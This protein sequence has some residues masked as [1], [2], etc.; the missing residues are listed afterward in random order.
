MTLLLAKR[1]CVFVGLLIVIMPVGVVCLGLLLGF[2]GITNLSGIFAGDSVVIVLAN[3][4]IIPIV[5]ASGAL[6]A[7]GNASFV[8]PTCN[9]GHPVMETYS[10]SSFRQLP[11]SSLSI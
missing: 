6:V 5:L 1:M 2:V 3:Q 4:I 8:V 7:H 9:N 10:M 11:L